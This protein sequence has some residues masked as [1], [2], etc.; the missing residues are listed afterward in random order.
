[1]DLSM[2]DDSIRFIMMLQDRLGVRTSASG[3]RMYLEFLD[4]LHETRTEHIS[5]ISSMEKVGSLLRDYPDLLAEYNAFLSEG[6]SINSIPD[7]SKTL[8]ILAAPFGSATYQYSQSKLE[9]WTFTPLNQG[10]NGSS[11]TFL[12]CTCRLNYEH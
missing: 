7:G 2:F 8:V 4:I 1:M 9:E 11:P 3:G 12:R 5:D 6:F 10:R